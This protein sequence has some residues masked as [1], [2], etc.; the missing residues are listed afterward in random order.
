MAT[1]YSDNIS[2]SDTTG[3]GTIATPYKT[4]VKCFSV[5]SNDD[6]INV[7]G[8]GYTDIPGT[9]GFTHNSATVTT[10]QNLTTLM[11]VGT[12]FSVKDPVFG[13]RKVFCKVNAIT[14]TTITLSNAVCYATG[15]YSVERLTTNHYTTGTS[16][17]NFEDLST[18]STK[19]GI[20]IQA[21]WTNNFTLQDGYTS[22]VFTA[23]GTSGTVLRGG[24]SNLLNIS[25]NNIIFASMNAFSGTTWNN[26][27]TPHKIGNLQFVTYTTVPAI[28]AVSIGVCNIGLNSLFTIDFSY[29]GIFPGLLNA[30]N[31]L[32]IDNLYLPA[33]TGGSVKGDYIKFVINNLWIKNSPVN[34]YSIKSNITNCVADIK[35]L[36]LEYTRDNQCFTLGGTGARIILRDILYH[37]LVTTL[38]PFFLKTSDC[39]LQVIIPSKNII[40][41]IPN[42]SGSIFIV[43]SVTLKGNPVNI[44][45]IEGDKLFTNGLIYSDNTQYSTGTNSLRIRKNGYKQTTS[46]NVPLVEISSFYMPEIPIPKTIVIRMKALDTSNVAICIGSNNNNTNLYSNS[47]IFK[48]ETFTVTNTWADYTFTQLQSSTNYNNYP[49]QYIYLS[50]STNT[51]GLTSE[52]VWIDSVTIT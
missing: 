29:G 41:I 34:Y 44:K 16:S 43:D 13:N 49:G 10:S 33:N 52:Y 2:G 37:G 38:G 45:D 8:S 14:T 48:L 40:Q 35:L 17:T 11:P 3:N 32:I 23:T 36:N 25:L 12:L 31:I 30:Y 20:Q 39:D 46:T 22:F 18:A 19:S 4:I 5:A 26:T 21:G 15:S 27:S 50:L 51:D 42:L 1:W 6:I 47:D 7:A 28:F 24:S 9:L